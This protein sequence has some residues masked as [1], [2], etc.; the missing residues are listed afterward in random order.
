MTN[1]QARESHPGS[2]EQPLLSHLIELRSRLLKATLFVFV[3]FGALAAYSNEIYNLIATPI[4]AHLPESSTMVATGVASPFLTPFKLTFIA[5][6]FLSM[7]IILYQIWA[8]IAPGLYKHEKRL[9][10]PLLIFSILLF[11]GGVAF[12]FY[13]VF[14]LVFAFLSTAAPD[15][16]AV[17]PDI[18]AYLD[19]VLTIF[20]AFGLAFQVPIA[21]I[22][23]VAAGLVS[24]SDLA[25]MRSYV[26]VAAFVIGMLLTPPDVISQTLLAIPI[27]LLFELGLLL[28]WFF[29]KR[30]ERLP[31][32]EF[33]QRQ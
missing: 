9:A 25:K 30:Q 4:I 33:E 24:R 12:A 32:Q 1:K 26:I 31:E 15:G 16:V 14:P 10:L 29:T 2:D 13:V 18:S 23:V 8:F 7:P 20:F 11:Y 21:T 6:I 19:F 27:W 17:I 3:V 28:S 5:A 22:V